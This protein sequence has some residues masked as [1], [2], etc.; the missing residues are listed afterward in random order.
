M[1]N[2]NFLI[3]IYLNIFYLSFLLTKTISTPIKIKLNRSFITE[4]NDNGKKIVKRDI[5]LDQWDPWKVSEI[6][7]F[8]KSPVK[9]DNVKK[10][11]EHIENNTCIKF[12]EVDSEFSDK[13]GLIFLEDIVC[14]SNVG[15]INPNKSQPIK[16]SSYCYDK[17]ELIL[18]EIGHALGLI[19]E[20]SRS[21]RDEYI[22]VDLNNV[23]DNEKHNFQ[24]MNYSS[25][26][27][28]S[29]QYDVKALMHYKPTDFAKNTKKPVITSRLHNAYQKNMGYSTKMTFNEIKQLNL[30]HCNKCNWVNKDGRK[31]KTNGTDR[32]RNGGYPNHNDCSK[33]I[34]PTGY[35]GTFC[36]EIEKSDDGCPD[37]IHKA[38]SNVKNLV[39]IDKKTCYIFLQATKGKKIKL[40]IISYTLTIKAF[41]TEENSNQIKYFQD[42][43]NTGLLLCGIHHYIELTSQSNSVLIVYRGQT[44]RDALGVGFIETD[45]SKETT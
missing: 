19:H 8:V 7:Y 31:T 39:M 21:D 17:V 11:I 34:C 40:Q 13:Q 44:D 43:G 10:A 22:S 27:N 24:I 25:Y 32:C 14:S 37:S 3:W 18:H 4:N 23:E 9:K 12:K 41:C 30:C 15:L 45:G 35:T 36:R 33:C 42:K 20:Q 6:Q 16:L 2:K 28:Y 26:R 5:L 38:Q 29:T 1:T